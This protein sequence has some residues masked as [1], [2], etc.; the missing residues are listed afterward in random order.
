MQE[1]GNAMA[2][3]RMT[4]PLPNY[5]ND[6]DAECNADYLQG[7]AYEEIR[8]LKVRVIPAQEMKASVLQSEL[9]AIKMNE[10]D[11]PQS[12]YD[13]LN[14]LTRLYMAS[15]GILMAL[16]KNTHLT[17]VSIQQI[18]QQKEK[19]HQKHSMT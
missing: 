4:V 1:N 5:Q 3:L 10:A 12:I 17:K 7:V 19:Q 14:E 18:R 11:D 8:Q 9:D 16:M 2:W 15:G 6:I 13:E